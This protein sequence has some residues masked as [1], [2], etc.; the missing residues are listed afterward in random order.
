LC[1][2]GASADLKWI[3]FG[4][5]TK[6]VGKKFPDETRNAFKDNGKEISLLVA[7]NMWQRH[8]VKPVAKPDSFI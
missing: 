1:L 6:D 3:A 5:E 4:N 2:I 8:A 7:E